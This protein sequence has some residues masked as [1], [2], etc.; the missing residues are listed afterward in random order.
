MRWPDVEP[1]GSFGFNPSADNS[2]TGKHKGLRSVFVHHRQF[3]IAAEGGSDYWL[4][5]FII[6]HLQRPDEPYRLTSLPK[7]LI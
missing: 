6:C 4:P 5:H 2:P 1:F 7:F 3:K